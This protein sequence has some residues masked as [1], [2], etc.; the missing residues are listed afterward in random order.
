MRTQGQDGSF[1]V[2]HPPLE[3]QM[4]MDAFAALP[5]S[6]PMIALLELDVTVPEAAIERLQR[7]GTRVSLFAFVVRSI[8]LAISEHPDLN[9][10]RHGRKLVRFADVDV[11]VPVEVSTPEGRFPREL[12]I[13]R[14]NALTPREVYSTIEAAQT[15]QRERGEVSAEDRAYRGLMRL[16][17]FTPAW[18]RVRLLRLAMRSAFGIKRKAGTTLVTSVGKFGAIPGFGFTLITGPRAAAF[19]VGPVVERPWVDHG[20]LAVRSVMTLSVIVNHDLVDG[21]PAA[22]FARR[23]QALIESGEGLS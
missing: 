4:A 9:L 23:L 10:I 12:I 20:Q 17:R 13:R 11:S 5:P 3:R 7:Q 14:A 2:I 21:G 19:A 1:E 18:V 6:H 15:R 8:A 22:R 16:V